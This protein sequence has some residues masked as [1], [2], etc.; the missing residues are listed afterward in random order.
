MLH[1][2]KVTYLIESSIVIGK[3]S[4]TDIKYITCDVPQ[5]LILGPLLFLAYVKELPNGS[6]LLD[7][8]MLPDSTN[9]F[10]QS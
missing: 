3:S 9:Y 6:S 4:R 1:G 10:L 5:G 2:L 7:P 8:I